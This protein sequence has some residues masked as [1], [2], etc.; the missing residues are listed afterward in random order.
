MTS[1]VVHPQAKPL[2]GRVPVPAD[3]AITQRALVLAALTD[4]FSTLRGHTFT[5]E[6]ECTRT[7]L[8]KLGVV[9][10]A[11]KEEKSLR[12]RGVGIYGLVPPKGP[13]DCGRSMTT[14][15]LLAGVLSAQDFESELTVSGEL[16]RE[17]LQ[18]LILPL[19]ER[20][21]RVSARGRGPLRGDAT[22]PLLVGALPEDAY[23]T[24]IEWQSEPSD[25][26][27]KGALLLS[28]LFAHGDTTLREGSLSL[29]HLERM[30]FALGL[31]V[32]ASGPL[33]HL[34]PA[35]WNGIIPAFDVML[36]GDY[37]S[38]A[39]L[40]AA[41]CLVAGS[42]VEVRGVGVNVTRAGFAEVLRDMRANFTSVVR[43]EELGEMVA[44]LSASASPL[45]A[46]ALGG[47]RASRSRSELV[48]MAA[49]LAFANGESQL[50]DLG[51]S[52]VELEATADVLRRFGKGARVEG[53]ALVIRG[54]AE[55]V[56][57]ARVASEGNPTIALLS[58]L[59]ALRGDGPTRI[60][61]ADCVT[62]IF[63]RFV[64]TLRAL[65]ASIDV[66]EG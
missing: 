27:L 59:L 13:L 38:A 49:L 8:S 15:A 50:R 29:D 23:L 21:A 26:D 60:D 20:G 18:H 43:S 14:L 19:R 5:E 22:A 52:A 11:S 24:G 3:R 41:G 1:L 33:V 62:R 7:C 42:N 4:G 6:T 48:P 51:V 9:I 53:T 39:M 10:E 2:V 57:A 30:F 61:G 65:G 54:N 12:V 37:S 44:D 36:P 66:L 40:V 63:P 35:G 16:A 47:E 45:S 25:A 28:G 64:G 17:P 31:P 32:R 46:I 34:S 56:S 58:A 55:P